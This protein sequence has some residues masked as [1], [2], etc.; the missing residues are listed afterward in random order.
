[1][2]GDTMLQRQEASQ[3]HFLALGIQ[4]N[5]FPTLSAS[6]HSADG[7]DQNLYQVMLYFVFASRIVYLG[8]GIDELFEQ[9]DSSDHSGMVTLL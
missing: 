4:R 5:V 2:G 6:N 3:P 1:M 9:G 7:H 8:K